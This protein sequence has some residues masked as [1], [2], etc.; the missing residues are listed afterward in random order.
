MADNRSTRFLLKA[1]TA[2][3][4]RVFIEPGLHRT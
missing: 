3:E 4:R 1:K 2:D